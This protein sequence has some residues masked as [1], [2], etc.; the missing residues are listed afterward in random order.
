MEEIH[1]RN[2]VVERIFSASTPQKTETNFTVSWH[3]TVMFT[4][5]HATQ[6]LA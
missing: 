6:R 5:R 4:M 2:N 3:R 1:M